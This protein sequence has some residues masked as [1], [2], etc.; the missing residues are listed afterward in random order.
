[1]ARWLCVAPEV[2]ACELT[3]GL[4]AAWGG[5]KKEGGRGG[6]EGEVSTDRRLGE[7]PGRVRLDKF[8]CCLYYSYPLS[9]SVFSLCPSSFPQL[10]PTSLY[11]EFRVYPSGL[12]KCP[13]LRETPVT[14]LVCVNAR[15]SCVFSAAP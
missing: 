6:G 7:V 13:Y 2:P 8:P 3:V 5:A 11:S 1:M 14:T 10:Y 4:P 9:L 15:V 12:H